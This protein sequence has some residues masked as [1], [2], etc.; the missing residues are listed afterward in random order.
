[1]PF[2]AG[3][4]I[5]TYEILAPIGAG[6]MGEVYRASD[7]RLGREVAIKFSA[8]R[9]SDRFEREARV[10][11]S[12]NHPNICT[13]HDV[14]ANYL[15]M[16]LV[17]GPTLADRIKQ[18]PIPYDL[19][20]KIAGQIADALEAAH[21]KGVVH[22]DLKPGN[23]KIKPDGMVKV[24]DF[25][26]AQTA[27][28][29][30]SDNSPTLTAN[31]TQ[32]GMILGQAAYMSPEQAK[33]KPV[34]KRTDIWAF[35][36]VLYEMLTGKRLFPGATTTEFMAAVIERQPQWDNIPRKARPLLQRCLEK[37]PKRRL[38]DIG[39]AMVWLESPPVSSP[40]AVS[41]RR[42]W[43]WPSIAAL[44]VITTALLAFFYF[45]ETPRTAQLTRLQI[46][47]P[48]NLT[49][50]PGT[51]AAISPDGRWI[52][53]P[54][55]GSNNVA[56]LWI[57]A[58]DSLDVKELPGT[59]VIPLAPPPFW[60]GDSRFVTYGDS[61]KLKKVDI[62]GGPPQTICEVPTIAQGGSSN[63]DG[64][65]IFG[66][67]TSSLMRCPAGGGA[68]AKLTSPASGDTAHRWP[69]FLPD[70]RHF[71]YFRSSSKQENTGI[72]VGSIDVKPEEQNLKPLLLS[73]REGYYAPAETGGAGWLLFIR[74][75]SL[76]AQRFDAAR[77]HLIG[78][79]TK[80]GG[81][82]GSFAGA[83]YGMFSV[84]ESGTLVH[85]R[86][87]AGALQLTWLDAQGK[88]LSTLGEP[89]YYGVS[90]VSPDGMR[91]AASIVGTNTD[92]W[93]LDVSRG[94]TTRL[95]FDPAVDRNPVW[96]PDGSRI[97]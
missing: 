28:A 54:A 15:V 85:R 80:I 19:A 88:V 57:R 33:G 43:I 72:F 79:P 26:L 92:I 22:R 63:H 67:N 59:D 64:V 56:R 36:V 37:D 74:E 5:G 89:G 55:V 61:G 83:N 18:G 13:L 29:V 49:F 12:L 86:G 65:V 21:E 51:A 24:L 27:S 47:V 35:G 70:G 11:A 62:S 7:T 17:E 87:G 82:V 34:D 91:I 6:G 46:P 69:Q 48:E 78:V 23:I 20:I 45:R 4:K 77:L 60:S 53:F 93:V 44:A 41:T 32:A 71:L 76:M 58:L 75:G 40:I 25:G 16:E 39:E 68:A 95:T 42:R 90:T 10:V 8:E 38:R 9:F 3:H 2:S 50:N 94:T 97:V 30:S 73:D 31:Q 84:A 52:A 1:M 81:P 14:G 66:S 96:S